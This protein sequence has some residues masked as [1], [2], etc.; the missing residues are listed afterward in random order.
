VVWATGSVANSG[1]A[2]LPSG[3]GDGSVANSKRSDCGT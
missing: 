2:E 3:V 1:R